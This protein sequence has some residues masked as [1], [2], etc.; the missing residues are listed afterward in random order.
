ML[1]NAPRLSPRR[2]R[3]TYARNTF[4]L[5]LVC[6][7]AALWAA[8]F[9]SHWRVFA[10]LGPWGTPQL[11]VAAIACA[12]ACFFPPARSAILKIRS[13]RRGSSVAAAFLAAAYL[14][15]NV[16]RQQRQIFPYIHDEFSYL[17]QAHQFARGR[18]W[19]PAHPLAPFFDSFQLLVDHVYASAY[20]PGTA[21]LHVPGLWLH[22]PPWVTALAAA[23]AVAGLL[24]WMVSR[25]VDPLA[26]WIAWLLLLSCQLFR[27]FSITTTAWVPLLLYALLACV[28]YLKWRETRRVRWAIGIGAFVGLACV[29]RPVDALCFALPL[30][31]AVLCDLLSEPRTWKPAVWMAAGLAPWLA[32]QLTINRGVTGHMFTTPFRVYADRDYPNT[33]Y[34]AYRYDPDAKPASDLPQKIVLY[35]EYLGEFAARRAGGAWHDLRNYRVPLTLSL[36]S[37]TPFPLLAM[38]LP[39]SVAG[40]SRRRWL[41]W[42]PLPLFLLLYVPYVFFFPSYTLVAAGSLIFAPIATARV[43]ARGGPST[44]LTLMIVVLAVAA[45]PEFDAGVR[46]DVFDAPLIRDVNAQLATI[47]GTAIVLFRFPRNNVHEEPVYNADVAWPDDA[48]V[49]RAHDRGSQ[50]AEL[51][52]YF[53]QR[54]PQ[55]SVYLY[56][57]ATHQLSLLGPVRQLAGGSP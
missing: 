47:K 52:R 53:A 40:L 48:R 6:L 7:G 56:D 12:A 57:E 29:T 2:P 45:L 10:T 20:F 5:A 30:A 9:G 49:I 24:H 41:L 32:L 35:R 54:Q 21:L 1:Y 39:L 8:L 55:R 33:A 34:G 3:A 23:A 14:A 4:E 42:A 36:S 38:L 26:G 44:W 51:F 17:I 19:M 22:L 13:P 31:I 46:D 16:W 28:A 27:T 43:V 50:N 18:L 25:M 37:S 15:F 11:V